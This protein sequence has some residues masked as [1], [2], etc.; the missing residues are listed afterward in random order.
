MGQLQPEDGAL[1]TGLQPYYRIQPSLGLHALM[2]Y[3]LFFP[4]HLAHPEVSMGNQVTPLLTRL[5]GSQQHSGHEG[6]RG[7]S[8]LIADRAS[9]QSPALL[10]SCGNRAKGPKGST[11]VYSILDTQ[12]QRA[13]SIST[14]H[15]ST[16]HPALSWHPIPLSLPTDLIGHSV[17][18][19]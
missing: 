18:K 10:Q 7:H 3:P 17:S 5:P 8:Q 4:A 16:T 6:S 19:L 12:P 14:L 9:C 11:L 1:L 15:A 13:T 2:Y